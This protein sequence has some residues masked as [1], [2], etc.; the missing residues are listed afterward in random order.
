MK[1]LPSAKSPLWQML[2]AGHFFVFAYI[3]ITRGFNLTN[4][5]LP[6]RF[7]IPPEVLALL[8]TLL[9]TVILAATA[10]RRHNRT[11]PKDKISMLQVMPPEFNDG[12]ERLSSITANATRNVYSYHN[13]ALPILAIT[14]LLLQ[15]PLPT[16][17][18][19]VGSLT[20]GHYI[21][22]WIGIRPALKD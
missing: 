19:L 21:A 22:Y 20:I 12:D 9:I 4:Y 3:L 5:T 11:H 1:H 13:L 17:L 15:P 8:G 16:T 18:V 7:T 6:M 10:V 14:L 2:F